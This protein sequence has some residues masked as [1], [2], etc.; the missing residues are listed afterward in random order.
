MSSRWQ[1]A[2]AL[3]VV[4]V[5]VIAVSCVDCVAAQV[6]PVQ[7][8]A[9]ET[10]FDRSSELATTCKLT[11]GVASADLHGSDDWVRGLHEIDIS[12]RFTPAPVNV[13]HFTLHS[14][15]TNHSVR[16]IWRGETLNCS[17]AC[18][19]LRRR[20]CVLIARSGIPNVYSDRSLV[21]WWRIRRRCVFAA[22]R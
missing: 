21:R 22:R 15:Y 20:V 5:V 9:L 10:Q 7:Y 18:F 4:V 8:S 19:S 16:M 17:I 13:H 6:L 1:C 3:A 12:Y 11:L 14:F 2:A